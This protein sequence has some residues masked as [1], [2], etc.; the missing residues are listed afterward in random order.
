CP[1]FALAPVVDAR[2]AP[3]DSG[4]PR[5]GDRIGSGIAG[6]H[7]QHHRLALAADFQLDHLL[8]GPV[9]ANSKPDSVPPSGESGDHP[10]RGVA[11]AWA[12]ATRFR[13]RAGSTATWRKGIGGTA[14]RRAHLWGHH[15][16]SLRPVPRRRWR[17]QAGG[18]DW[19]TPWLGTW[20][21]GMDLRVRRGRG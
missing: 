10:P 5:D 14:A 11:A 1:S 20:R 21:R 12:A 16:V 6:P 17:R 18:G 9:G 2:A 8:R 15:A 19:S 3:R 13:L 4:C 7:R